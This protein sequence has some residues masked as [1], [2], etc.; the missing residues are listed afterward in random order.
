MAQKLPELVGA[1]W[2]DL[3]SAALLELDAEKLKIRI[4]EA[5]QAIAGRYATLDPARDA[6]ETQRM[7]DA[8]SNLSVLRREAKST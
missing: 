1:A 4:N 3:Y 2:Q 7:S 5:E 6:D 8:M